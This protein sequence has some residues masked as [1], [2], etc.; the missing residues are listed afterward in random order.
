MQGWY[1]REASSGDSMAVAQ[2]EAP[3][4]TVHPLVAATMMCS[5]LRALEQ[6]ANCVEHCE[7]ICKDMVAT[8]YCR[9][10]ML[11]DLVA[12]VHR[13]QEHA[14]SVNAALIAILQTA[15]SATDELYRCGTN[16]FPVEELDIFLRL[17]QGSCLQVRQ[18]AATS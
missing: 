18:R 1:C 9:A 14:A 11:C 10:G 6:A 16:N 2:P 7:A 13:A 5:Q 12:S 8:A 15:E 4:V 17:Y 3:Q